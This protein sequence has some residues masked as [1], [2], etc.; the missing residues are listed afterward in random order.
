MNDKQIVAYVRKMIVTNLDANECI[1]E[2][3]SIQ[4]DTSN[5]LLLEHIKGVI[6]LLEKAKE[7]LEDKNGKQ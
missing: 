1:N 3:I 2:A 7:I 4:L 6:K 5:T